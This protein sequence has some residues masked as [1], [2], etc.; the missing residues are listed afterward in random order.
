MPTIPAPPAG[1]TGVIEVKLHNIHELFQSLDPS[2]FPH[3]D[4][5]S[6]VEEFIVE[7]AREH[8][9]RGPLELRVHLTERADAD[10]HGRLEQAVQSYF[11][12]RRDVAA[13]RF[14]HKIADGWLSLLI[15]I[16]FL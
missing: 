6:D 13:R 12:A 9:T 5:D 14:R 7:W 8:P 3:Q 11:A 4:L 2:P 1:Q 15:G 16:I 10:T